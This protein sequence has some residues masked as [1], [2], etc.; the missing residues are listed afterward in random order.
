MQCYA[1][2]PRARIRYAISWPAHHVAEGAATRWTVEP[3]EA[4]GVRIEA[5]AEAD[6]CGV[7]TLAGGVA[8]SVYRVTA[9]MGALTRTLAIRAEAG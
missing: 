3:A 1:K 8:G 7:A 2:H 4:G 9:R 6:G 5:P